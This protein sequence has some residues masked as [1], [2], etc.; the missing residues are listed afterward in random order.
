MEMDINN[1]TPRILICCKVPSDNPMGCFS[2]AKLLKVGMQYHMTHCQVHDWYTDVYL[3][4]FPG[5]AFNSVLFEEMLTHREMI[6]SKLKHPRRSFLLLS[7][8]QDTKLSVN[9]HIVTISKKTLEKMSEND[10]LV[11]G[12]SSMCDII[13][14]PE[15]KCVSRIHFYVVKQED[16][17]L[18]IDCSLNGTQL[19]L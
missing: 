9:G 11:G 6:E 5:K 10:L 16:K 17:Y 19:L 12:R 15:D 2:N 13:V 8:A 4:E 1:N 3:K 14:A 7:S 18:F